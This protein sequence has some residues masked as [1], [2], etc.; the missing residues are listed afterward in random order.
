MNMHTGIFVELAKNLSK[1]GYV[2]T[3]FDQRGH[4]KSEGE[5]GY[6]DS[7]KEVMKDCENF[8]TEVTKL[9]SNVPVYLLGTGSG[10]LVCLNISKMTKLNIA[11]IILIST[12]LKQPGN[13]KVMSSISGAA[14]KLMPN[15]TGLFAPDY[16]RYCKNPKASDFITNDPNVCHSKIMVGTLTQMTTMM[17]NV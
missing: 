2:F 14:L 7:Y 3:G 4:G 13:S 11:G 17:E 5:R 16:T 9:Y 15:K 1:N 10:G 12:T 8:I 6:I